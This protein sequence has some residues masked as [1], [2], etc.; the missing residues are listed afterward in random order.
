MKR[1]ISLTRHG[2]PIYVP[3][4]VPLADHDVKAELT[5]DDAYIETVQSH[6][7]NPLD[8]DGLEAKD[9]LDM[10]QTL[11]ASLIADGE[12]SR[13]ARWAAGKM[14]GWARDYPDATWS[15]ARQN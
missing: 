4:S 6:G 11:V 8:L 15:I 1:T 5:I 10:L 12:S 2:E 3:S 14:A 7:H 9:T 13:E